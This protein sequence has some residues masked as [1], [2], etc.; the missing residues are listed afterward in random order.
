MAQAPR[1]ASAQVQ[2]PELDPQ[3]MLVFA[4]LAR[5]GG[6]RS[7][8]A[9]L[10]VPRSTI[11][12]RLAQL[13]E[14]LGAPLVVRTAR[15]FALTELGAAFAARCEALESLLA[16]AADDVRRGSSEVAG[17]LR[18]SAAPVFGEEILPS[19][20]ARL[21]A[22]NP[23]LAVD[24]RLAVDY[25]DLRR[26]DVDVALRAWPLDDASDLFAVKLGTSVT[27]CWASPSYVKARGLP[28]APADLA[29][30][31]CILVGSAPQVSW[32]FGAAEREESVV[33]RGRARVDSFR[34][35][36]DLAA[37]G[38]GIVRTAVMLAAPLVAEGLLVAVLEPYWVRTPIHAVHAGSNPPPAKLRALLALLK[39]AVPRALA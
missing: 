10:A 2:M 12:R 26:G 5:A 6:V 18:I 8:A 37:S 27:G 23:R 15:R 25:V 33:V 22:D 3:A 13:E 17:T 4:A 39:D 31:D 24:V 29:K 35:A 16:A 14:S 36:R 38:A 30:H 19:I 21:L 32:S 9:T 20:I 28:G 7:A 34:L 1:R 11:S